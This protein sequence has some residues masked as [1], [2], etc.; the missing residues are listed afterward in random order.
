MNA[1][2]AEALQAWKPAG[3]GPLDHVVS[4]VPK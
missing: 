1:E 2:L 4:H 3:A